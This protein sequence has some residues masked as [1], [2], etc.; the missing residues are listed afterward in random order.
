MAAFNSRR[1][2]R[3]FRK[4]WRKAQ[5]VSETSG[6]QHMVCAYLADG[7]P[8]YFVVPKDMDDEEIRETVFTLRHG[9]PMNDAEKLL[10]LV[11]HGDLVRTA[12]KVI[13]HYLTRDPLPGDLLENGTVTDAA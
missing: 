10:D 9:R 5:Q 8:Q 3:L 1:N 4:A 12:E 11:A 7:V 2:K 13:D 6:V